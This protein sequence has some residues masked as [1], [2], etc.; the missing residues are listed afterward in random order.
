M[1]GWER[2][3]LPP[4]YAF[5][6]SWKYNLECNNDTG[7][8]SQDKINLENETASECWYRKRERAFWDFHVVFRAAFICQRGV[9]RRAPNPKL[10]VASGKYKLEGRG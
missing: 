5:M 1:N 4:F 6:I 2:Y 8:L 9:G 10:V 7:P 3:G